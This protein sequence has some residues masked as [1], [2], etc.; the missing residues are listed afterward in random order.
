MLV[1]KPQQTRMDREWALV[2]PY[3]LY[4]NSIL[5]NG[6]NDGVTP[7]IRYGGPAQRAPI[8]TA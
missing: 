8:H 7:V 5:N 4:N 3:I 2:E 1:A 6:K